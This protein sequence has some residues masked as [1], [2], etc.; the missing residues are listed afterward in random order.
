[1]SRAIAYLN[2]QIL[3]THK[4]Y[5]WIQ[6]S[7]PPFSCSSLLPSQCSVVVFAHF[8]VLALFT[9]SNLSEVGGAI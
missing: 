8:T 6:I 1:M 5:S 7:L 2:Y 3:M 4:G 9:N